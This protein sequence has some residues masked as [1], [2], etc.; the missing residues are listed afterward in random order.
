MPQSDELWCGTHQLWLHLTAEAQALVD[1][2]ET[3]ETGSAVGSTAPPQWSDWEM[4]KNS[5]R[6]Q[7]PQAAE[8]EFPDD[9]EE[10]HSVGST[11]IP[12]TP[13]MQAFAAPEGLRAAQ[14]PRGSCPG[15]RGTQLHQVRSIAE[16]R[17]QPLLVR[18][19]A[20]AEIKADR[21]IVPALEM[22]SVHSLKTL[23][24]SLDEVRSD[25]RISQVAKFVDTGGSDAQDLQLSKLQ[26]VSS[27]APKLMPLFGP[28]HV[29]HPKAGAFKPLF[30]VNQA[31]PP[32]NACPASFDPIEKRRIARFERAVDNFLKTE[33]KGKSGTSSTAS[34][35]SGRISEG[36]V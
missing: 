17:V 12:S 24:N 11:A 19:G 27:E 26:G 15:R 31:E 28:N 25:P 29:G 20:V 22:S 36:S 16:R 9:F 33:K 32:E 23:F 7:A 6:V 5:P 14:P 34:G 8:I 30:T 10:G 18:D 2:P 3:T 1:A 13:E 21:P 4:R 35:R